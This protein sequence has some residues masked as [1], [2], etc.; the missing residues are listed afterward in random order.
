MAGSG[1]PPNQMEVDGLKTRFMVATTET[2]NKRKSD[3]CHAFDGELVRFGFVCCNDEKNVDG[4]CGCLRSMIGQTSAMATTTF[5]VVE[6]EFTVDELVECMNNSFVKSGF[7][8]CIEMATND[9][10]EIIRIASHFPVG[11]VV[12]KRGK[13]FKER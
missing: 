2:Q 10:N 1:R 3:F 7:G 6:L 9:V 13:F 8:E 12:E 4:Q 5:K 11:A